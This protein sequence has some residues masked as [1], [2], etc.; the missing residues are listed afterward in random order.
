MKTKTIWKNDEHFESFDANLKISLDGNRKEGFNPKAMLLSSLAGCSGI[1]V[2]DILKKMRVELLALEIEVEAE[3]TE[4]HPKVFKDIHIR[5]LA[6]TDPSNRDKLVRAIEL[7]LNK[8]CGVAA[9][10]RK[11][12]EIHYTLEIEHG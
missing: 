11:N 9:M 10:L 12:S 6:K 2:V 3:Q 7:S 8:Y 1:D 4:E 5:Y